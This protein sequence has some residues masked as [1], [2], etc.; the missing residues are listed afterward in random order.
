M[1]LNKYASILP[2]P[3]TT[4]IWVALYFSAT[5]AGLA[6]QPNSRE[7]ANKPEIEITSKE[8][9]PAFILAK[10]VRG[11]WTVQSISR[12]RPKWEP[13]LEIFTYPQLSIS[14]ENPEKY[15]GNVRPGVAG[16]FTGRI[17]GD[18]YECNPRTRKVYSGCTTSFNKFIN[19]DFFGIAGNSRYSFD[20]EAYS[21]AKSQI[22]EDQKMVNLDYDYR[23]VSAIN[24]TDLERIKELY[25]RPLRELTYSERK[26]LLVS[27]GQLSGN[28]EV[29]GVGTAITTPEL[30]HDAAIEI[31]DYWEKQQ[32]A[33]TKKLLQSQDEGEIRKQIEALTNPDKSNWANF[34]FNNSRSQLASR[35]L[36]LQAQ[37]TTE[38]EARQMRA[39]AEELELQRFRQEIEVGKD[40]FCGPVVEIRRP[41]VKIYLNTQLPGFSPEVWLKIN[42][43]YPVNYGCNNV[44]GK[45]SPYRRSMQH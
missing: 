41:M 12:Q 1:H 8:T 10:K 13:D 15:N 31:R 18:I 5:S 43:L 38:M 27:Y 36:D 25:F 4:S 28:V 42:D 29:L 32:I 45:I 16:G 26:L 23:I 17:S 14:F 35:I 24:G 19:T 11:T 33:K 7:P 3:A 6:A 44:N 9:P 37:R 2:K 40:T 22:M 39:K 21:E 30:A 34:D 20:N